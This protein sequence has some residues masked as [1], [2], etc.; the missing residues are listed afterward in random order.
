MASRS[1]RST[2]GSSSNSSSSPSVVAAMAASTV[3]SDEFPSETAIRQRRA[4]KGFCSPASTARA[5]GLDGP[6]DVADRPG[7]LERRDADEHIDGSVAVQQGC[8]IIAE[9]AVR[10]ALQGWP[11]SR[12]TWSEAFDHDGG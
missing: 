11:P 1:G 4:G 9:H 7:V 10:Q 6:D 5:A 12:W 8:G 2:L 3:P